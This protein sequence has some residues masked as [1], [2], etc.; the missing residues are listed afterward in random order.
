MP[1]RVATDDQWKAGINGVICYAPTTDLDGQIVP[2]HY[3]ASVVGTNV[4]SC[5]KCHDGVQKHARFFHVSRGWYGHVRGSDKIFSFHPMEPGSVSRNGASFSPQ[6]RRQF[7]ASGVV[8]V[9]DAA[10]HPAS[11]YHSLEK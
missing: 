4:D 8:A 1:F 9:Y 10:K 7:V 3:A 6:L 2:K 11:V 5:A